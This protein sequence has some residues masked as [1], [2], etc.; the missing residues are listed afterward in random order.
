MVERRWQEI[1]GGS[2]KEGWRL[3]V[4][5]YRGSS[6]RPGAYLQA[7]LHADE[8]PGVAVIHAL[9]GLVE[10]AEAEGRLREDVVLVPYANPI[11]LAQV[12]D[13]RHLGRF[14]LAS[15]INF[16]RAFPLPNGAR[17]GD[18]QAPA[19]R[20]DLALK[21]ALLKLAA[22][23]QVVLDLHCDK[24]ACLYVYAHAEFWPSA[25]DLAARLGAAAVLLWSGP[26]EGG[27]AFE[28]AVTI[29]RLPAT[30]A[31]PFLS[32]TVELRG[33]ADVDAGLA[34]RDAEALYGLLVDRAIVVEAGVGPCP[35]WNGPAV[36]QEQVVNVPAP[37]LGALLLE[38]PVGRRV[39]KGECLAR[40]LAEPG[41]AAGEVKV[42]APVDGLLIIRALDRL[43]RPGDTIATII[44]D[45][46]A[47]GS[48]AGRMLAT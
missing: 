9:A 32:S 25:R 33:R 47:P 38:I 23:A 28:E 22:G 19:P 6:G 24:D 42:L 29:D 1:P 31:R 4:L 11:G 13:G 26:E 48:A 34:K 39:T 27:A 16:N 7:A 12:I 15:G 40:I 18:G 35:A 8:Q 20:A 14:H 2:A 41:H 3:P 21:A 5:T 44:T 36:R 45:R 30:A 10:R 46:P 43:A 17:A 37:A